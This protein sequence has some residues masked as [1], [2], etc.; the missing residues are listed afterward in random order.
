MSRP[1]LT[2]HPHQTNQEL[3]HAYRTA[4]DPIERSHR[5]I[6]WLYAQRGNADAVATLTAYSAAWVRELV[7]R[8]NRDGPT[9]LRDLRHDNRGEGR[10]L[11]PNQQEA[12]REAL[13]RSAPDA[14]LWTSA[15]VATWIEA[16]TGQAVSVVTGWKYLRRLEHTLQVPRPRHRDSATP[17]QREAFKK[18]SRG[19]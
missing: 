9:A 12:L 13:G 3:E 16:T 2:L 15:K 6:I 4:T 14:G 18:S 11:A 19:T 17:E 8:Y 5:H 7:K 10:L 1:R